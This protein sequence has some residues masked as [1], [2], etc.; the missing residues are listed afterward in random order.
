[1]VGVNVNDGDARKQEAIALLRSRYFIEQFIEEENL[2]PVLF[3][4]R[5]DAA[6][7]SWQQSF[8]KKVPTL[9]MGFYEFDRGIRRIG[10]DRSTGLVVLTIDWRD[11]Y[12]AAEWARKLVA[13]VNEHMRLRAIEEAQRSIQ[14]LERERDRTGVVEVQ[15][16]IYRLI[17][18]Q[19]KTIM[20]ANVREEFAF[21]II[22]PGVIPDDDDFIRPKRVLII[23]LGF[24]LGLFVGIVF[25]FFKYVYRAAD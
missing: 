11:R 8:M 17:E 22:D 2:L 9:G 1:M 14:Y 15:Q 4:D 3:A 25:V 18:D 6:T 10:E 19:I 23:V 21:R 20:L 12:Q 7:Q 13:R 5:W 24:V 16:A